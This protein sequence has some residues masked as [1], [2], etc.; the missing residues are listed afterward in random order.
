MIK[1]IINVAV[2]AH[3]DA[4]KSTLIDAFLSQSGVLSKHKEK[5]DCIMD[6]FD[7]ERERGITIYSKNCSCFY[8]D[9]K[10]NIIDTPGHAD[11]SSEVERIISSVDTAILIVDSSE[12]PMPQ[13]RFVLKK[14]LEEGLKPILLINKIDKKDRRIDEVL[15][16]SF[17]LFS[18]LD[19]TEEQLDFK[20]LYSI[21]K[22]EIVKYEIDDTNE[23]I[24]PL[25]ETIIN[26]VEV[27]DR[28]KEELKLQISALHYDDY[29]GRLGVGRIQKG[30]LKANENIKIYRRDGKIEE[31]KIGSI[32]IYEGLKKVKVDKAFTNDMVVVSGISDINI[33][34]GIT[35]LQNDEVFKHIEIEKPTLSMNFYVNTSPFVGKA[36]FLTTRH[37]K[38]RLLKELE[39]NVGLIVEEI[40]NSE[41]FKVSGRGELHLSILIE[42]MR[43]EGFELSISKPEVLLKRENNI[44]LEPYETLNISA[45]DEY[46]GT[47]ISVLNSKKGIMKEMVAK[48]GYTDLVYSITTR[49]LLGYKSEFINSTRGEGILIRAF[50]HYDKYIGELPRRANGVLVSGERGTSVAYALSHLSSRGELFIGPKTEVYEGMIVGLNNR[51]EDM[52]VNPCKNKKQ[53]NTRA[54]GSDEAL[55]NISPR[56]FSLEEALEF[57]ES[58][59]WVEVTPEAIRLRKKYLTYNERVKKS[60]KGERIEK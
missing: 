35:S 2:I 4:G 19:A 60:K 45:P 37:L 6:S 12:G 58:D 38:K 14:A 56:D 55:K 8:K 32:F 40:D 29:I 23:D 33:G 36:K 16:M 26:S 18:D 30:E 5:S 51:K 41:A 54:S 34:D 3:V 44:L 24:I 1:K 20:V 22:K 39:T 43:R 10:I 21:A 31:K 27:P 59:E 17:E 52:V 28:S 11:F 50:S 57:I 46:I 53:S 13:T 42:N 9:Y 48:E 25:F 7:L 47:I 15:D 49:A